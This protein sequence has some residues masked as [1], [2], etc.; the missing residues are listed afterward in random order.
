[1]NSKQKK[2]EGEREKRLLE[3]AVISADD[4]GMLANE[5]DITEEELHPPHKDGRS[6]HPR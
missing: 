2:A 4:T 3:Q 5:R 6:A 1:M